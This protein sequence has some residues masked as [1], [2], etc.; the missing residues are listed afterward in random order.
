[1]SDD[2]VNCILRWQTPKSFKEGQSF[3]GFANF[4]RRFIRNFSAIVEPLTDANKKDKKSRQ[5]TP[6]MD[7]AFRI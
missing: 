4:Y 6:A 3:A 7:D 5:W 1:M 2:K